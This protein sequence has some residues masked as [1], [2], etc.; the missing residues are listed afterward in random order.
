VEYIRDISERVR[1]R[2]YK[3]LSQSRESA[4]DENKQLRVDLRK[5]EEERAKLQAEYQTLQ[6]AHE[7]ELTRISSDL[8]VKSYELER[9]KLV[10]DELKVNFEDLTD[11]REALAAKFDIVKA[12]VMKLE[13]DVKIRDQQIQVLSDRLTV[14]E[15][16]ESELDVAIET[17]D[18]NTFGPIAVPSDANRRVR[19]SVML[20]RR[21]MQLTAA[22]NQ[23]T[24]ECEALKQ[25]LVNARQEMGEMKSRLDASGQ[26]QQVFVGMLSEKQQEIQALRSKLASLQ[27]LNQELVHEKESLQHDVKIVSRKNTDIAQARTFSGCFLCSDADAPTRETVDPAPF[28]ITRHD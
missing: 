1:E 3:I 20:A 27:E 4:I 25:E 15:K 17:L 13:H 9:V 23:L 28:I 26:P 18:L 7:A 19:Q 21:V 8:R 11:D 24:A 6:L 2:E 16:L 12:E 5:A 10:Y 22:N 14:Y